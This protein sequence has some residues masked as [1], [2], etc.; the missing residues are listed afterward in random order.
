MFTSVLRLSSFVL[1]QNHMRHGH[2]EKEV[3]MADQTISEAPVASAV[4]G[5]RC[6][7]A[8]RTL[9]DWALIGAVVGAVLW[10]IVTAWA[11]LTW[12]VIGLVIYE[13]L[14]PLVNRLARTM[15]R[16]LAAMITLLLVLGLLVAAVAFLV[17]PLIT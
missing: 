1:R 2:I 10:L 17:P 13:L 4:A 15:P 7:P 9:V 8:W 14:L 6:W 12:F 3:M 16:W 5:V 11:S